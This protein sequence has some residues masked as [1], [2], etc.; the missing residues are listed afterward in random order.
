MNLYYLS[1][2]NNLL[3]LFSKL[4]CEFVIIYIKRKKAILNRKRLKMLIDFDYFC[5][6]NLL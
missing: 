1:K 4:I 3:I 2:T 6:L 5:I